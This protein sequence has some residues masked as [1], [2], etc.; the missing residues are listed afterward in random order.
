MGQTVNGGQAFT[1]SVL[2]VAGLIFVGGWVAGSVAEQNKPV[3]VQTVTVTV[4]PD[5]PAE[6]SPTATVAPVVVR[7][8]QRPAP[9]PSK[10]HDDDSDDHDSGDHI[11]RE[12]EKFNKNP[13]GYKP[14]KTCDSECQ[15]KIADYG[16]D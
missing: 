14:D 8:I 7:P 6:P 1:T 2:V 16:D 5:P 12:A 13:D 9:K 10:H 3:P 11:K 4:T 15:F